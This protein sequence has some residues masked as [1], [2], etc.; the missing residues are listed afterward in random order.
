MSPESLME[1]QQISGAKCDTSSTPSTDC[2]HLPGYCQ[3]MSF[4]AATLLMYME[5]AVLVFVSPTV[6]VP[7]FSRISRLRESMDV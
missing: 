4:V 1:W 2:G 6:L 7:F 3:S 5:E